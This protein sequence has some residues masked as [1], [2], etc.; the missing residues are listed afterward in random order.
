MR[1][2][3]YLH[4]RLV[5][6]GIGLALALLLSLAMALPGL[7][8]DSYDV[9][10]YDVQGRSVGSA[11][12]T[13]SDGMVDATIA[14]SGLDPV[15]GSSKV[16]LVDG[17]T[18]APPTM[19]D[20]GEVVAD[21]GDVQ[22]FAG[23]TID[24]SVS[25]SSMG[26]GDFLVVYADTG[27]EPGDVIVC[28]I[29][30]DAMMDEDMSGDESMDEDMAG[31]EEMDE[32]MDE[33]MSDD[34]DMDD[35]MDD[36]MSDDEDMDEEMSDD[37]DMD[38][39]M[40]DDM[41][42]P[43]SIQ[44]YDVQDRMVGSATLTSVEDGVQIDVE[45]SGLDPLG[46]VNDHGIHIH[47]VGL[48]EPST[49]FTSASGHYNPSGASHG[50][51]S[52]DGSHAGDLPNMAFNGDGSGSYSV[53]TDL[54]TLSE[55][56]D[57]DG[58]ALVIHAGPDDYLTDPSGNSGDRIVCGVIAAS[59]AEMDMDEEMDEE[60]DED[61]SD[62]DMDEEMDE[63]MS[64]LDED[65]SDDEM[66]EDMSGDMSEM[67]PSEPVTVNLYDMQGRTVGTAMV[68]QND[69]I[70]TATVAASSL[71]EAYGSSSIAIVSGGSCEPPTMPN[72]ATLVGMLGDLQRFG[73]TTLDGTVSAESGWGSY[74]VVYA[75]VGEDP[76]DVVLCGHLP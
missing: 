55:L 30:P 29:L 59:S 76:G 48:C 53:T 8:E 67:G 57:A 40:S 61:M 32:E 13:M 52:A 12:I 34:E 31:D 63:D 37:E 4:Q 20:D 60:M 74:L 69:G 71:D 27:D 44:L 56:Y 21:L 51:L 7:A 66:D 9:T 22:R 45:V 35:E 6:V 43:V 3:F 11:S 28:G 75:D 1:S 64:R 72:D 54:F 19:P 26:E 39:E 15:L 17:G 58:S 10:L 23:T 65:M 68:S 70:V 73:G 2:M 38:D 49:T 62:E 41:A 5:V 18:C 14:V 36:D 16:A 25:G 42:G 50:L 33:D 47:G 24:A 46:R